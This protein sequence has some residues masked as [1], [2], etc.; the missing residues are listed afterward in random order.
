[1]VFENFLLHHQLLFFLL[2][3]KEE[4]YIYI[5]AH[6]DIVTYYRDARNNNNKKHVDWNVV[7][8]E[9]QFIHCILSAQASFTYIPTSQ[10]LEVLQKVVM[11][12]CPKN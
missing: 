11:A 8:P 6:T 7:V 9:W 1:M 3:G 4:T 2:F 12:G 5:N 10:Y